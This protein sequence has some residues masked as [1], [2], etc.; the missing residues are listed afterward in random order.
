MIFKC[1]QGL[2]NIEERLEK[3]DTLKERLEKITKT[4]CIGML[5]ERL[6]KITKTLC[7]GTFKENKKR[8]MYGKNE[9][10]V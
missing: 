4:L 2:S 6:E 3:L 10:M 8:S 7:M 9:G 1:G 5:K